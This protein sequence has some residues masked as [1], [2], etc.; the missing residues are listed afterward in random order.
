MV[1]RLFPRKG[2]LL[3]RTVIS[4]VALASLVCVRKAFVLFLFCAHPS[5]NSGLSCP[6]IWS[7]L[8][9]TSQ[10]GNVSVVFL[11]LQML[12]TSPF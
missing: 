12:K 6:P 2:S 7:S 10:L 11:V 5:D 8:A 4:A 9:F 1:S 3:T